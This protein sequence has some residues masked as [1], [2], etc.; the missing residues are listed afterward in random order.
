MGGLP[1]IFESNSAQIL[2]LSHRRQRESETYGLVNCKSITCIQGV[3]T[4]Y[5]EVSGIQ[6]G[7]SSQVIVVLGD[8]RYAAGHSL[9]HACLLLT[10]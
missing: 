4:W 2:Q 7:G 10:K 1:R 6:K 8:K 3:M 9:G 5:R